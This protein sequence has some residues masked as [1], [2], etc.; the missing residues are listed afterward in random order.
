MRFR[1]AVA[2]FLILTAGVAT[3]QMS[4]PDQQPTVADA[5]RFVA[6][7][8]QQLARLNVDAQRAAW[9]AATYITEDTQMMSAKEN[10]RFIAAGV[11]LAKQAARYDKLDL[12]YDIRRKLDLIKLKLTSPGPSDPAATAELARIS[13]ELE[14]AYGAGKYCPPGKTGE[15]CLD[16]NEI[17]KIM[18]ESHDPNQL[19][20]VWR[21]WQTISPP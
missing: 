5:T 18:R 17:S 7:A 4:K 6:E 1:I 16:I 12:P 19:L 14:A 2:L 10:E 8:E 15:D 9:V 20:D 3:A 13:A 21:G 11:D